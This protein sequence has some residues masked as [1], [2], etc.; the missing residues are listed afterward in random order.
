MLFDLSS[1]SWQFDFMLIGEQWEWDWEVRTNTCRLIVAERELPSGTVFFLRGPRSSCTAISFSALS[2]NSALNIKNIM[3]TYKSDSF[4]PRSTLIVD[5][6]DTSCG[7]L[8]PPG[9]CLCPQYSGTPHCAGWIAWK[10]RNTHRNSRRHSAS[11]R[12]CHRKPHRAPAREVS[13]PSCKKWLQVNERVRPPF[14][15]FIVESLC[16]QISGQVANF[17]HH[18]SAITLIVNEHIKVGKGRKLLPHPKWMAFWCFTPLNGNSKNSLRCALSALKSVFYFLLCDVEW[19]APY[20]SLTF[21]SLLFTTHATHWLSWFTKKKKLSDKDG[22]SQWEDWTYMSSTGECTLCTLCVTRQ[23]HPIPH[24]SW[25]LS[26]CNAMKWIIDKS[27]KCLNALNKEEQRWRRVSATRSL[28]MQ[29]TAME[30]IDILFQS[31]FNGGM[32]S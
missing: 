1:S 14:L 22:V 27:L 20:F 3:Y 25:M 15:L 17:C 29:A 12:I 24:I 30:A 10:S 18:L 2:S 16:D 9:S 5:K 32:E 31:L 13:V 19:R 26:E 7:V 6:L 4:L 28:S 21:H 8:Y 23:S 11:R